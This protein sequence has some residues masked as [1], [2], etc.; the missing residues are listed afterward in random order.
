M[1]WRQVADR[2]EEEIRRGAVG[3][4]A[5]LPTEAVLSAQFGVHR[6][7]VRRALAALAEKGL[8][9]ATRGSGTF[10]EGALLPYPIASRT[11]FSEIVAGRGREPG[12][13]LLSTTSVPAEAEVARALGL[14]EGTIVMRLETL[15]SADGV[16]L[17]FARS[18]LPL[19][20]FEQLPALL[21]AGST[22]SAAFE[23]F[24]VGDYRR[25][26]TRITARTARPEEADR[27][28]VAPGRVVLAVES[29]DIDG[30]G[31]P[32]QAA[33]AVF[34]ADRVEIVVEGPAER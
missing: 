31:A 7:T 16:P 11:R 25:G 5:Q 17:S 24:G 18:H 29:V 6:H 10:V 32:I 12:G 27:L 23:R 15:R 21:E 2:I 28:E 26:E 19:P 1:A 30:A 22:L 9:R 13:R 8:V 4:G 33:V 14:E 34:A 3:P 20:R